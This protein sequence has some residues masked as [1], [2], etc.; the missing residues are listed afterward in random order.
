MGVLGLAPFLQKICPEAIKT[1]PNRL[2]SLSGKTVV[3]DGTLITQR[4]HFAPMPHPYR[5]V[6]GWYRIMQ[7]LKECDVNAICVF[8][9]ME[10]SHAKGRETA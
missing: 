3:I 8:D 6:L 1:L 2:K 7:E 5:H 9:G 10:R 4:L